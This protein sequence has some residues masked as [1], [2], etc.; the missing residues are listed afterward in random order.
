MKDRVLYTYSKFNKIQK[1][2]IWLPF[3]YSL[4][5]FRHHA[6]SGVKKIGDC[7]GLALDNFFVCQSG[8]SLFLL[9]MII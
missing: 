9:S 6:L 4:V 7:C 8:K 1:S 3:F 2:D 5:I